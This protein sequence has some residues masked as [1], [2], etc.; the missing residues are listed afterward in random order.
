MLLAC[1]A[2]Y[3]PARLW[4]PPAIAPWFWLLVPPLGLATTAVALGWL[5]IWF[6][7]STG[8]WL[9][10]G[11]ALAAD[12][13]VLVRRGPSLPE[14]AW[15]EVTVVLGLALVGLVV[16]IGPLWGKPELLSL[17]PN[18][19]IEIHLP[20]AA[21]LTSFPSGF[22]LSNPAG[23]PFPAPANP[24]LWR[25]N[26]FDPRWAGLAFTQW[27]GTAGVV[28]G[29]EVHHYLVGLLALLYGL[30]IPAAFLFF[31]SATGL[32]ALPSLAATAAL[33]FNPASL[34][35]VYWSFG[36]QASALP[37][38]PMAM[39]L[40]WY[41]IR[42]PQAGTVALAALALAGLLA[43]FAPLA[44][45]YGMWLAALCV[46]QW[47]TSDARLRVLWGALGL[48]GLSALMAPWAYLRGLQR[49]FHGLS[50][51]GI[52]GLTQGPNVVVFPTLGW[53][54]GLVPSPGSGL[55]G[56][57]DPTT[58]W[59][60]VVAAALQLGA[61]AVLTLG[62]FWGL[63][64]KQWPLA[65]AGLVLTA[66]L[67]VLRYGAPYP[68]GYQKLMASSSFLFLGL[69][70]LGAQALWQW[71]STPWANKVVRG[72]LIVGAG[73]F[74]TFNLSSL[75]HLMESMRSQSAMAYRPLE[76]LERII[77]PNASVFVSGQEE[78]QGPK[79]GALAYFLRN[80]D[81]YGYLRTGYSTFFRKSPD[82]VYQ[83]AIYHT[84]E[85]APEELY[86]AEDKVWEGLDLKVYR[87]PQDLL[88]VE[89]V[90]LGVTPPV[91]ERS[92]GQGK[93]SGLRLM[94]WREDGAPA[95]AG[96]SPPL[97]GV[98]ADTVPPQDLY[99]SAVRG[100]HWEAMVPQERLA[101]PTKAAQGTLVVTLATFRSQQ[102][103]LDIDGLAHTLEVQRGV[104]SHTL[105]RVALPAK[106]TL[107]NEGDLP[108][109]VKSVVVRES[110]LQRP[111][112]THNN[113]VLLR[114]R[115]G[116]GEP[117]LTLDLDYVGPR[118]Q[119]TI[120][121]YGESGEPHLGWWSLPSATSTAGRAYRMRLRPA[122]PALM[123]QERQRGTFLTGWQG[124]PQQGNYRAHFFLWAQSTLVRAI[125][126]IAFSVREDGQVEL[127]H[128]STSGLFIG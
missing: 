26:F 41:A 36:Q 68:Y 87:S 2:G 18:W 104:S 61:L 107:R 127:L 44:L 13:Y 117:D 82:G 76:E 65:I 52:E 7:L 96:W 81:L 20:L 16:A 56:I 48:L 40:A 122:V 4:L 5:N 1:L 32:G 85:G 34:W 71:S 17:G 63:R 62:I 30:T 37:L 102:V 23:G 98:L 93:A 64:T 80:M 42:S 89:Q 95:F 11:A 19:D 114:W 10:V 27:L 15:R 22:S 12:A 51:G 57:L 106:V 119:A 121:I 84:S 112:F 33:A 45:L 109:Y 86:R 91:I 90:G 92:G 53:A 74:M 120:D 69:L 49:F 47:S 29:G 77:P 3:A 14:Q 99:P 54:L 108:V 59:N 38:L 24:L 110:L 9:L 67:I 123:L 46:A 113:T 72:L 50:E 111:Q 70:F 8:A 101:V 43:S 83:Y 103:T 21:Y 58:P 28:T 66:L 116:G 39:L 105:A 100:K 126:L 60:A 125:P 118:H 75:P 124:E 55:G 73:L 94:H 6:P 128:G 79:A 115:A 31:R 35:M 78:Y 97:L 25:V 88:M